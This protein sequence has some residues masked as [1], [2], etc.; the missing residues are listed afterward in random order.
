MSLAEKYK[1]TIQKALFHKDK[2]RC[3]QKWAKNIK[4]D[5]DNWVFSKKNSINKPNFK[6]ILFIYGP[7]S[8]GKS[9]LVDI[10]FKG[11]NMININSE[12]LKIKEKLEEILPG[13][14][15]FDSISLENVCGNNKKQ[16]FN[17]VLVDDVELCDK[18]INSFIDSIKTNI[19]I[20]LIS[21]NK[22]NVKNL[23]SKE[24]P[25]TFIEI[26]KVTLMELSQMISLINSEEKLN[27]NE[28][29]IK[30][31]IEKSFFDVR[32]V[33]DILEQIKTRKNTDFFQNDLDVEDV[34]SNVIEE[35][36]VDMDLN[37][38]LS[39]I[40]SND[41]EFNYSKTSLMCTCDPQMISNGIYQNYIETCD[42]NSISKIIND[43]ALS[44]FMYKSIYSDQS[45]E[46]FDNYS[47]I[48]CVLPT[49]NIKKFYKETYEANEMPVEIEIKPFKDISYN[50]INSFEELKNLTSKN[51]LNEILTSEYRILKNI[52]DISIVF[53]SIINII[54]ILN[55]YFDSKKKG[56]NTSKKEKFDLYELI[57]KESKDNVCVI[58][59]NKLTDIIYSYRLFE[60]DNFLE[61]LNNLNYPITIEKR[62]IFIEKNIDKLDLRILK[63]YIN[64]VSIQ[65]APIKLI[66]T[67]T[68]TSI[69]LKIFE[70]L[71]KEMENNYLEKIKTIKDRNNNIESLSIS[72]ND[73]W[74]L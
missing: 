46:L 66:K 4:D 27:L 12:D 47:E 11:F 48:G 59:L 24:I 69:K 37:E 58:M 9:T 43:I 51:L 20:I 41:N 30:K 35:K 53:K 15:S 2:V 62:N 14:G 72:L 67:H 42:L 3:I 68:E 1:P 54:N 23:F 63:R 16:K 26:S 61:E 18:N 36:Y 73:L 44:D 65:S 29:S 60:C 21:S 55:D 45:W 49:Y 40:F 52:D 17:M 28:D 13:I 39:Y 71:L 19:P 7:I 56:K 5:Y 25:V 57:L 22:I 8:C 64:L 32:Q 70:Y 50:Y 6:K 31:I 34:L 10:L 38:K 74:K 33:F